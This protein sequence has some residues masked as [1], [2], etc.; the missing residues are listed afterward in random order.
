MYGARY[1]TL[2][3]Y[4]SGEAVATIFLIK[5]TLPSLVLLIKLVNGIEAIRQIDHL[6]MDEEEDAS[7][8]IDLTT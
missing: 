4:N 5:N 7:D 1:V 2:L 6:N 3:I 8:E